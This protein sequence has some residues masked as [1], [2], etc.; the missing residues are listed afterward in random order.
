MYLS[1]ETM[2][3]FMEEEAIKPK[4]IFVLSMKTTI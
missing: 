4:G 2:G 3:A 1:D